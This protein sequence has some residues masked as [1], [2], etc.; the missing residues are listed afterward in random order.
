MKE[1]T[2]LQLR[3]LGAAIFP[4]PAP[5]PT[6]HRAP[7]R[8]RCSR[9]RAGTGLQLCPLKGGKPRGKVVVT[10]PR[11]EPQAAGSLEGPDERARSSPPGDVAGPGTQGNGS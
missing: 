10:W 8:R 2:R 3:R 6:M 9:G 11:A 1:E 4:T 5:L 7:L